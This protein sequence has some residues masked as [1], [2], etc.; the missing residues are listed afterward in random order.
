MSPRAKKTEESQDVPKKRVVSAAEAAARARGFKGNE[1]L[2][3]QFGIED[4]FV[5]ETVKVSELPTPPA[6]EA[7]AA[8]ATTSR[9]PQAVNVEAAILQIF[10]EEAEEIHIRLE[11]FG[12][13]FTQA[14]QQ[15]VVDHLFALLAMNGQGLLVGGGA[16]AR[17]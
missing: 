15:D 3:E 12:I 4:N 6:T 7:M 5:R 9:L 13:P 10:Q 11:R 1:K 2:K 8:S 14:M 16:L 17:R